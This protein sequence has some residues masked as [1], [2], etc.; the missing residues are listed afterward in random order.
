MLSNGPLDAISLW[1]VFVLTVALVLLA[2]EGGFQF[3]RR[4]HARVADEQAG[5]VGT[6]VSSTLGLLA[7][8]LA[9]VF[10]FAAGRVDARRTALME[11]ANAIGTTYLRADML[12]E[13]HRA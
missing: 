7:F 5:P 2:V 4:R 12:P 10:S 3:G 11:E 1:G 9:F 8:I 13:P 6:M